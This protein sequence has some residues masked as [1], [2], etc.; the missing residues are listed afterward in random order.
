MIIKIFPA[1]KKEDINYDLKMKKAMVWAKKRKNLQKE[2]K[3]TN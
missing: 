1:K 2:E 3:V